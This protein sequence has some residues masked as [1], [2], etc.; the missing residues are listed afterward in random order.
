LKNRGLQN[1]QTPYFLTNFG[2]LGMANIKLSSNKITSFGGLF[3]IS[4]V[5]KKQQVSKLINDQLGERPPQSTY[6]NS[7][8]ILS[9]YNTLL[10]G[11]DCL[12]D[13]GKLH[14]FYKG[15]AHFQLPSPDTAANV[16]RNFAQENDIVF[17]QSGS[18][19]RIN[20]CFFPNNLIKEL[21]AKK[22][23]KET[24]D[25]LDIDTSVFKNEKADGGYTYNGKFGYNPIAAT[26]NKFVVDVELRSGN[27]SPKLQIHQYTLRIIQELKDK[28]IHIKKVRID[29]AGYNF[30][31]ME[32]LKEMGIDFYI[33]AVTC[34]ENKR[35]YGKIE[36]WE[37]IK[38]NKQTI[39][40]GEVMWNGFRL[41]VIRKSNKTG[42]IDMTS[43]TCFDYHAIIT[44]D[45]KSITEIV[46]NF[47]AKRGGSERIFDY[48]NNDF[49]WAK[50]P[51]NNMP[52]NAV[53]MCFCA[54]CYNLFELTKSWL[55]KSYSW[56]EQ[57]FRTKKFLFSFLAVPAKITK[58]ARQTYITLFTS[59][60]LF[61]KFDTG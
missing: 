46:F 49:G 61:T 27:A 25:T 17:S 54:F 40:I 19:N 18:E 47:Y 48:L 60:S 29:S 13:I 8:I 9:L 57:N 15:N 16:C 38:Q 32:D 12:E 14:D 3:F 4:D 41:V 34:E 37:Q 24:M 39:E 22:A 45:T 26:I 55:S 10:L 21:L 1:L 35:L 28:G 7:D 5:L 20:N 11:G 53:W 31:L 23:D 2:E 44:N 52:E 43:Q 59:N 33:R 58:R 50:L 42:Q 56:I 30:D 36:K 51:F 6:Y